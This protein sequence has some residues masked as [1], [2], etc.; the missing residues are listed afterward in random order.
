MY[1]KLNNGEQVNLC[2]NFEIAKFVF[3]VL[4]PRKLEFVGI[5]PRL[6]MTPDVK[7]LYELSGMFARRRELQKRMEEEFQDFDDDIPF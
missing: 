7:K 2:N 3:F 1:Y 5:K 4:K 6:V